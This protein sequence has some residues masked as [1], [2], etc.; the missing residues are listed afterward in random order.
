[1]DDNKTMTKRQESDNQQKE[2]LRKLGYSENVIS[3]LFPENEKD[4]F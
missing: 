1:M 4:A 2:Y 3:A